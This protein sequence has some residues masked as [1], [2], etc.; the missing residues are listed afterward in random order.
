M[1]FRRSVPRAVLVLVLLLVLLGLA[2]TLPAPPAAASL[3]IYADALG[4]GWNDWSWDPITRNLSNPLPVHTGSDSIAVAYTDGWS[5]LKLSRNGDQIDGSLYDTLSFWVNGGTSGG[6]HIT[7]NLEGTGVGGGVLITPTA[8]TWTQVNLPLSQFGSPSLIVAVDWYNNTSSSQPTFYLDDISLLNL[9][10][11]T[12]NTPPPSVGPALTVNAA[13]GQHPISPDIYG[14]NF[15]D[16]ALAADIDLPVNRWGGNATTR[17]NWQLDISNHASD[18]YFENIDNANSNPGALPNGSS[19]DLFVSQNRASGTD[20]LLTLPLIGWTP[21][22]PRGANPRNCGFNTGS[23]GAQQ[24]TAPDAPNCG[25]GVKPDGTTRV[26]GN[27]PLDTSIAISPTFVAGWINHLTGKYGAAASGGVKFYDLD[28]EPM[29]WSSTQR[30]VHPN[31]TTYD[32]LGAKTFAYAAAVKVADPAAQTLGPVPWGWCAYFYSAADGCNKGN[33]YTSHGNMYF[34]DWYLQQM[35]SYEQQHGVR[36]LDYLDLHMYPQAGGVA[37]SGAGSADTQAL[38]LR[39]TRSLWDPTYVDESWIGQ[40]VDLI[41]RMKAWVAADYPGTKLAVSEYNWGALDNING[42]VTQADVLG[43]FGREGLD[44]ATLWAP[45]TSSQPGAYAF[46]L[47]RNYDGA[48][49]RFGDTSVLATSGD[50]SQLAVYAA[51]RSSDSA[52]TVLVV[53]KSL[54][55]TLTSS[56]GLSGFT[57]GSPAAV[58]RYSSADLQ[59]IVHQPD[60]AV[61][62]GG[63]TAD[64]PPQ[65]LTLFVLTPG[66]DQPTAT[67]TGTATATNTPAGTNTPTVTATSTPSATTTKTGTPTATRTPTFTPTKT[68]TA[69]VTGTPTPTRTSTAT[70]TNTPTPSV[71]ATQ[72]ATG[73]ASATST[74]TPT[75][76]GTSTTTATPSRTATVTPTVPASGTPTPTATPTKTTVASP[77]ATPTA[78]TSRPSA[79]YWTYLPVAV[80]NGAPNGIPPSDVEELSKPR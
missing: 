11:P 19:S 34:L 57:P 7:I 47:Y 39:S 54:T 17:Y 78:T 58:Y 25:N 53:N 65:S 21:K 26:T 29:L 60:Q 37:L 59:H 13:A 27:N 18:W 31:P 67:S 32:E 35:K 2:F 51:L 41:P 68:A 61:T 80:S 55:Q 10:L 44:L 12:P 9:G 14:L 56:L 24:Y 52:L 76:T 40:A 36:I 77:T 45:P 22:G 62:S 43:I 30:D 63:F 73:M 48:H 20:S 79:K 33:D 70:T 15:A 1:S 5:G 42:A 75:A 23:Y 3:A 66:G 64:Y 71:T 6:Q 46:R 28:N 69:T 16:P 38:R 4:T 72:T 8:N 74:A 50:Q 49:H